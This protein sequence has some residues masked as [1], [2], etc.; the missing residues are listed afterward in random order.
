MERTRKF[1]FDTKKSFS[2]S[3]DRLPGLATELSCWQ[4]LRTGLT[5]ICQGG[6][7]RT[8]PV[9]GQGE[10]PF[11]TL[12]SSV[13][14]QFIT[15]WETVLSKTWLSSWKII[16]CFLLIHRH[17]HISLISIFHQTNTNLAAI[18]NKNCCH[19]VY[20]KNLPPV[21]WTWSNPCPWSS[22][23]L[24]QLAS[25]LGMLRQLSKAVG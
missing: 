13:F 22:A 7:G 12:S 20:V 10:W 23:A 25:L 8:N 5:N 6:L 14:Y 1:Q 11:K 2:K 16:L 24:S 18:Q 4:F 15:H 21:W 3:K 19:R 9:S 17:Y